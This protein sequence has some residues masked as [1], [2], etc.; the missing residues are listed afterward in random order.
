[1]LVS[2]APP[3]STLAVK[4]T[5]LFELSTPGL[6][7]GSM[8]MIL[9]NTGSRLQPGG[10]RDVSAGVMGPP[11]PALYGVYAFN[12]CSPVS[13]DLS[14]DQCTPSRKSMPSDGSHSSWPRPAILFFF[15]RLWPVSRLRCQAPPCSVATDN[16]PSSP[17]VSAPDT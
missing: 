7:A 17:S 5:A 4:S 2:F 11:A 13:S 3:R 9:A 15:P 16:R 12:K 6:E 10:E 1:M 8:P 14:C